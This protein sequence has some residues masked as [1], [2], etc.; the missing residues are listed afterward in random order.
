MKTSFVLVTLL[1]HVMLQL[2]SSLALRI[3][4]TN[5]GLLMAPVVMQAKVTSI[6]IVAN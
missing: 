3:A 4:S 2:Y 1:K 6:A 5:T